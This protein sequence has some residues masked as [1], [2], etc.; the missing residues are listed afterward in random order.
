V[1]ILDAIVQPA[2]DLA[3]VD[4]AQALERRAIGSKPIRDDRLGLAMLVK[5]LSQ[6][7]QCCLLVTTLRDEAFEHLALVIDSAPEIVFHPVDLHEN[8]VEVPSSM[9]ERPHRLDPATTDLRGENGAKPVP[10]E[11][12][13]FMRD[14]DASLVQQVFDIPQRKW[15]SDVHHHRKADDLGRRLEVTKYAGIAHAVRLAAHPSNGKP[16][17]L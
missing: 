13:R 6:E 15:V 10:P 4:C 14:V 11:P 5:R 9:P 16:I 12:D 17:F 7:F 2:A 1:G 3:L 8:L